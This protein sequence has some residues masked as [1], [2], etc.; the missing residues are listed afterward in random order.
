MKVQI[1]IVILCVAAMSGC[2]RDA[3]EY[4]KSGDAYVAEKKF[5]DAIV[6]Y[7]NA[8]NKDPQDG[9]AR[10]KL[11]D[12]YVAEK[13][14]RNALREYV[15]AADLLPQSRDAQMK[16]GQILLIAGSFE[17]AKGRAEK[18]LA[19]NP[20]DV[21]GLMI[22]AAASAGLKDYDGALNRVQEAIEIEPSRAGAYVNL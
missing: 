3:A 17:D 22:R 15:R 10:L 20:K 8:V 1:S 5:K 21:D 18:M 9:N 7:R 12:A 6:E 14:G 19:L 2:S 13:D 16:A 4:V 11:A